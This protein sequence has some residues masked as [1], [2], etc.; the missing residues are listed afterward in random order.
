VRRALALVAL[1]TAWLATAPAAFAV[2]FTV[3]DPGDDPDF[4]AGDGSCSTDNT[5][6][7]PCTLRA[8]IEEAN[9]L[10]GSDDVK[11][12]VNAVAPLAPLPPV[13]AGLV[14]DGGG[15]VTVTWPAAV[16]GTLLAVSASGSA[17]NRITLTGGGTGPADSVL[18]VSGSGF[19][20]TGLTVRDTA[21]TG[22]AVTGGSAA[23]TGPTVFAA[24]GSGIALRGSAGKVTDANVH[25]ISGEGIS[26]SGNGSRIE[27]GQSHHNSSNGIGIGSQGVVVSRT[28]LFANGGKPIAL[29]P[30]ANGG[31]QPPH[32][33]RIGPRRGDGSLPLT[34]VSDPGSIELWGG[35][36]FSS[37][38]PTFL[39]A[40]AVPGADF[41]HT[42]GSEP[43]PGAQFSLN[44]TGGGGT[45]EYTVV[46]VPGDVVSPDVATA[47][48]V[49][50][51]EVRIQP[52]EPVDAAT[53]QPGDFTLFMAGS[54]RTIDY[55][56]ATEDGSAIVL[57]SSGWKAGEAG[58]VTVNAPAAL[59]DQSGNENLNATRLRVFAAPGDFVAPTGSEL[60][61]APKT[62]CLTRASTCRKP[63]MVIQVITTERG[64]AAVVLQRGN[65]RIGSRTYSVTE[66]MNKLKF[67][68]RLNGRKLRVG[69]YRLL[70]FLTD[71]V[72]NETTEPPIT[73]FTIRR[74]TR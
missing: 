63:G 2:T 4:A 13:T 67:N 37:V 58:F 41:S 3:N 19:K 72:G 36:P 18:G 69:R 21:A 42:F 27:G 74:T 57:N 62:V 73:L 71:Q 46:T 11:F 59:T 22:I 53:I 54:Q 48:A 24:K 40:F 25:N 10:A 9:L 15:T 28:Q 5:P 44:L 61:V 29:L 43:Q 33:V 30:S 34:G 52:T 65:K 47:R 60:K 7:G 16:P 20:S 17:V 8:A 35:S 1:L 68:G 45:S 49:S 55:A 6:T 50:T 66:G 51:S 26:V 32:D 23:F 14:I 31:I 39:D 12:S 38:A 56:A 70:V 64:K